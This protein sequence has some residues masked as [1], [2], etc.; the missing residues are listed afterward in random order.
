MGL[1]GRG[2]GKGRM[3]QAMFATMNMMMG[4]MRKGGGGGGKGNVKG[5]AKAG[6][7]EAVEEV[8]QVTGEITQWK[9][10]HGWITPDTS[11]DHPVAQMNGGRIFVLSKD[12]T[13]EGKEL[14]VGNK[15]HFIVYAD[16]KGLGAT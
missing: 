16:S 9:G 12:V 1:K 3:M 10:N 5:K 11:I 7:R 8:G 4:G 2:R 14:E 15:V 6:P 13:G